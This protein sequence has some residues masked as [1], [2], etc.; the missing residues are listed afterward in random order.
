MVLWQE[1]CFTF[2][3]KRIAAQIQP[4]QSFFVIY[5]CYS[6]LQAKS[7]K[8]GQK[9]LKRFKVNRKK[10]NYWYPLRDVT[11]GRLKCRQLTMFAWLFDRHGLQIW[12]TWNFIT[13]LT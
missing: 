8:K 7:T 12:S 5:H 11:D 9:M 6:V 13:I 4:V 1:Q 3:F 10:K 2:Y